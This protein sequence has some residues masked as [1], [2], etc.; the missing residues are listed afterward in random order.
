MD[1]AVKPVAPANAASRP[2]SQYGRLRLNLRRIRLGRRDN[3]WIWFRISA[4]GIGGSALQIA[5]MHRLL[6]LKRR[7]ISEERF[8]NALSYCIAMPGPETQQLSI[9]IGWLTHRAMG[10]V[11]AGGLFMLPGVICMMALSFGFVT[12]ANSQFGQAIF[13]GVKPAILAIMTEAIVRFGRQVLYGRWMYAVAAVAFAAAFAKIAFPAIIAFAALAGLAAVVIGLPIRTRNGSDA[14]TD[15][16]ADALPDHTRPSKIRI[17]RTL[18]TWIALWL[19]PP[20]A[21][22]AILGPA[23]IFTQISMLFSK[24]ALMAIGGDYAVIAYGAQ[25]AVDVYHW[26]SAREMQDGIAMGEM[27]PGTIMI[28]TQF[29]GFMAAF[30]DPGHLPPLVAGTLGGLI[31]TWATFLPCF[32]WIFAIAPFIEHLRQNSLLDGPLRAITAAAVGMIINLS[33]WF[34][35]RTLFHDLAPVRY[36]GLSFDVPSVSSVSSVDAWAVA[37]FAA[38]AILVLRFKFS[39]V[40]TLAMS[41]AAGMILIYLGLPGVPS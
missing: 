1:A 36:A 27:V 33:V 17:A 9:Y 2:A 15:P 6:V 35:I 23:N 21:L 29:L 34:G 10:G 31:A 3:L 28:V 30:R 39:A 4:A 7:W 26:I 20:V 14:V 19:A 11:V 37:L 40:P 25:E 5:T 38:S 32:V 13:F 24:V 12:G 16:T 41:C 8:F 18:A 22:L